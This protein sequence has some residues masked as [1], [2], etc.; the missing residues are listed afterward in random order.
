MVHST[1]PLLWKGKDDR[2]DCNNYRGV[3]LLSV[4]GN[5]FAQIIIII[6]RIHHHLLEHQHPEQS[7]FTPKW[8]TIDGIIAL[9][10][11]TEC[12][13]EFQQ[14]LLAA[15]VDLHKAFDSVSQDAFWRILHLRWVP[16][17]LLNMISELYSG[18]ESAVRCGSSISDLHYKAKCMRTPILI[19]GFGHLSHSHCWQVYKTKHTAIQSP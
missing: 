6:D 10:V 17:K 16:P 7:G 1:P 8:S 11:L 5:V 12:R 15:Y 3:T 18:T 14:E 19:S 9:L 13:W 2:Q 4:P